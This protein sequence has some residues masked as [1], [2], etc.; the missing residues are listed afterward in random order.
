MITEVIGPCT[1]LCGNAYQLM[2][3]LEIKEVTVCITDP[4]YEIATVGGGMA[5]SKSCNYLKEI[6][7][8]KIDKGFDLSLFLPFNNFISFCSKDQIKDFILYAEENKCRWQLLTW[9]KKS[10]TPLINNNY[11]PDTEYI[12]HIWKNRKLT[13]VY[14][15][16]KKYFLTNA[17]KLGL[18]H[19]SVK[20]IS[21]M[22][23]LINVSSVEGDLVFDPFMGTGS[24]GVACVLTGRRFI[25]IERDEKHFKTACKRIEDQ[26]AIMG[27]VQHRNPKGLIF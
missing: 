18:D 11:M 27:K 1:L 10:A 16:K 25:G 12:F 14:E 15:D 21:I 13:G 3:T 2:K 5:K 17:E 19:P 20:P 7:S 22:K 26:L 6:K 8:N 9:H 23:P 24:T 4:P